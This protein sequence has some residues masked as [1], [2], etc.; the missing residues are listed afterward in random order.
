MKITHITIP[1]GIKTISVKSNVE[2]SN[3][4][5]YYGND[6]DLYCYNI[7]INKYEKTKNIKRN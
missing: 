3:M 2:F 6:T 1:I 7:K 4:N 5:P